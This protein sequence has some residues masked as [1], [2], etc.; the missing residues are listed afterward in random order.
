MI[1]ETYPR[2]THINQTLFNDRLIARAGIVH[3]KLDIRPLR[4][5]Y[6]EGG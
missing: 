3:N 1:R 6:G 5:P 2:D 4:A